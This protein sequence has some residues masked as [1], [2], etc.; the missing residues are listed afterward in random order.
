MKS[1]SSTPQ[2][3]GDILIVD[4]MPDNLRLLST[5]LQTRGYQVRKAIN[6]RIALHGAHL[7]PPDLIL[8]DINMPDIN[9]YEVCKR[10][11][12]DDITTEIPIIFISALDQAIDKVRAFEI[13]AVD[14]I[15]K[16]FQ[17]REVLV[18]VE[19]Q[20]SLHR[21]QRQLRAKNKQLE[22]EIAVRQ[23]AE[24]EVRF[25]LS[26]TQAI[27]EASDFDAALEV[28]L[29][30]VCRLIDWDYSEAWIPDD[31][32]EVLQCSRGWYAREPQLSSFRLA[33]EQ[34]DFKPYQGLAGRIWATQHFEWL[35]DLCGHDSG[36]KLE[37]L[38]AVGLRTAFG[39]PIV[40]DDQVLAVMLFLNQAAVVPDWRL[41]E[42][43]QA[44]ATQ[45]GSLI[46]RKKPR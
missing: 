16:P 28:T 10:L 5:M 15:T 29:S 20:L 33:S 24:D 11:K 38:M 19:N 12:A 21:L 7:S 18:R 44:T 23:R 27:G 30:Q 32:G 25:L 45:L 41:I 9:G 14:Y 17:V 26:T 13:G 6:G 4:D 42:L 2:R 36:F 37:V 35:E 3:R 34:L 43:V 22:L 1:A 40:L 31:S 46:Q 39:V 8:L